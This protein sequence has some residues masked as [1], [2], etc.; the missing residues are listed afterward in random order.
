[1]TRP[2][3]R[4]EPKL[5]AQSMVSYELRAPIS[6]HRR[7][8]S[9]RE[10][11]CEAYAYGWVTTV[12]VATDLGAAQANYIRLHSGR[13]YTVQETGTLVAFTF[14]AGQ[15]CFERHTVTLERDPLLI[16]RGGDW[17]GNPTRMMRRHSSIESWVDD[18]ATHQQ[19]IAD[20]VQEG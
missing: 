17:R 12:D 2:L 8:A 7:A 16:V 15:R 4:V 20:A 11:E 6:T 5:P 9:C 10:F 3:F 1:V 18:F 14:A 13:A 19:Q